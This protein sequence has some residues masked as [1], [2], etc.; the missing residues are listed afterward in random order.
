MLFFTCFI[1]F[2]LLFFYQVGREPRIAKLT[3]VVEGL[4]AFLECSNPQIRL[5]S[6]FR[7]VLIIFLH[8]FTSVEERILN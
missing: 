3:H 6:H 7:V 4:V 5:L 2:I 1:F 8:N